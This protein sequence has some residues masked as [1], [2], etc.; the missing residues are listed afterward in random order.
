MVVVAVGSDAGGGGSVAAA[1][2]ERVAGEVM[3]V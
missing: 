2:A 1:E 3:E